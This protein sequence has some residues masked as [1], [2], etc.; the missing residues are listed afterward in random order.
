[1][2]NRGA[3]V[4]R[5]RNQPRTA[6][7]HGKV[8]HDEFASRERK[9]FDEERPVDPDTHLSFR[10]SP[11]SVLN[12]KARVTKHEMDALFLDESMLGSLR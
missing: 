9:A 1:M 5:N 3:L 2:V 10:G 8:V 7:H 11:L 6:K 4:G 12:K